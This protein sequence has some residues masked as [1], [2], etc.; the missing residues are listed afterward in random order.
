MKINEYP[1][2]YILSASFFAFVKKFYKSQLIILNL[3]GFP[4][5]EVKEEMT[6]DL[7]VYI[8]KHLKKSDS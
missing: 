6:C 5:L 7:L 1:S 2:Y 8:P 3:C 4:T